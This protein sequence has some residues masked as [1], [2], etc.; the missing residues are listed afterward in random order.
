MERPSR[1]PNFEKTPW[2]W[3]YG[4][5]LGRKVDPTNPSPRLCMAKA[6]DQP[7]A[8]NEAKLTEQRWKNP[9]TNHRP[10]RC[11]RGYHEI[12]VEA[13]PAGQPA[14]SSHEGADPPKGDKRDDDPVQAKA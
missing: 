1:S 8:D 11:I 7:I 9:D 6:D 5:G 13:S 12:M 2:V 14:S 10:K 4:D 3:S